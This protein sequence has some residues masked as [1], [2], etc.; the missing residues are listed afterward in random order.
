[1]AETGTT[2]SFEKILS[3]RKRDKDQAQMD[4]QHSVTNFETKA[5]Q[6]YHLLSKKEY[7]EEKYQNFLKN[8]S[9]ITQLASHSTYIEKIKLQIRQLEELVSRARSEMEGKQGKLTDAHVEVKKFEKLI[10][11]KKQLQEE[12]LMHQESVLMDEA[13]AIQFL[14]SRIR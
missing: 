13:S 7:M 11:R 4:Y 10:E 2:H 5:T 14:K 6:L 8:S 3:V 12:K 9:T 1:M